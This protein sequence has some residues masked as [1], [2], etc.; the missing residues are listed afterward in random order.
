[1]HRRLRELDRLEQEIG[2]GA[3][4]THTPVGRMPRTH[5]AGRASRRER[6]QHGPVI[7][8]LVIA[9]L[10]MGG[11]LLLDPSQSGRR[12]RELTGLDGRLGQLV[13]ISDAGG[14]YA[15]VHTQP[16]SEEPVSWNP[17]RPIRYVVNPSGA[18]EDWEPLVEEAVAE[19]EE[20]TGFRFEDKGTSEDRDFV[21][22]VDGLGRPDPVLIAWADASEVPGLAGD[23][24]CL[25]G[26]TYVEQHH[27]RAYVSGS[28]A[29]DRE[30]FEDLQSEPDG[31]ALSRAILVHELGHVVGL[32]HVEDRGELMH[33]G[34]VGRTELG[35][36]D[37]EGLARLGSVECA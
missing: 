32:D 37:R 11:V 33:A 4:P 1:M 2:L 14:Q 34:N 3:S 9:G 7:P 10:I 28:V 27:R 8:G 20:A 19:I 30:L 23:V 26:S 29:L 17:C 6:K 25:G 36:G 35:P 22:R 12:L 15:F 24:A 21:H 18:P 13:G 5:R 16:G 31:E